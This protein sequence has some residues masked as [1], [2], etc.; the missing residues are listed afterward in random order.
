MHAIARQASDDAAACVTVLVNEA[1]ADVHG[2]DLQGE[3]LFSLQ[4]T[5]SAVVM[6]TAGQIM[7]VKAKVLL[8]LGLIPSYNTSMGS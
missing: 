8:Y 3:C 4:A 5:C 6:Q 1:A 2:I 7:Q